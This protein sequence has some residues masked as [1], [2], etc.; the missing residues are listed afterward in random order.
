MNTRHLSVVMFTDIKGYTLLM[1]TDEAAAMKLRVRHREVFEAAHE[2]FN[3]TVIQYFGDGTLSTFKSSKDAVECAIHM[4]MAFKESPKVPLRIGLH[5]G[6]II[7]S[8][9]GIAGDAVNVASRV[10]SLGVPGSI[11]ISAKVFDDIKNQ[12]GI[13]T[14]S[15]GFFEF[16]NV[17]QPKEVF[18]IA[19]SGLVV[20]DPDTLVGK[21]KV[22]GARKEANRN[23]GHVIQDLWNRKVFL[24]AGIYLI[25]LWILLSAANFIVSNY[26]ISPYWPDVLWVFFISFLPSII[27]HSYYH[28]RLEINRMRL[29]EKITIPSNA[30]LSIALLVFLFWGKDLGATTQ[31]LVSK[32][33][34]GNKVEREVVKNEFRKETN[35]YPYSNHTSDS[36]L[37]WLESGITVMVA[38]DLAQEDYTWNGYF[39]DKE[40]LG[41][42]LEHAQST[43]A[44]YFITGHFEKEAG[45][46]VITTQLYEAKYGNLLNERTVRGENLFE[47]GDEISLQL[48]K[49][50][51]M[52]VYFIQNSPDLPISTILT[53]N[54]EAYRY[55]IQSQ[56]AAGIME[57]LNNH[58][59][60]DQ[61]DSTFALNNFFWASY[62]HYFS[63]P[64]EA[65][66]I[67]DKAMRHRKRVSQW[68]S[69][70]I[71]RMYYNIHNQPKKAIAL[72]E[73]QAE[74]FPED[75]DVYG[76]LPFEYLKNG[77]YEKALEASQRLDEIFPLTSNELFQ[78]Q[79]LTYLNRS[80]EGLDL[81]NTYVKKNPKDPQGF[82]QLGD[83]HLAL[84]N[85]DEA[86]NIFN[87]V[88]LINPENTSM[89]LMLEH[90]QYIRE[91]EED[92]LVEKF[93]PLI[94]EYRQSHSEMTA[95]FTFL[96]KKLMCQAKHQNIFQLYPIN[97]SM[98]ISSF[99]GEMTL[100]KNKE[101]KVYQIIQ[102]Q[103]RSTYIWYSLDASIQKA[104]NLL[105]EG[106]DGA[107][108]EAYKTAYAQNPDHHFLQ[109]FIQHLKFKLR[110]TA[111]PPATQWKKWLGNYYGSQNEE[112][113]R[114][115][116]LTNDVLDW[117]SPG[118]LSS[119]LLPINERAFI[120]SKQWGTKVFFHEEPGKDRWIEWV[121]EGGFKKSFVKVD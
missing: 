18:A 44:P 61:L 84:G 5:L 77:Y 72:M 85:L 62:L 103:G 110:H 67:I 53:E 117:R 37:D 31:T 46:Y 45:M 112:G 101:G 60:A 2:K 102:K 96:D 21:T 118:G 68:N 24:A 107:A 34:F 20:P 12:K 69:L 66:A 82:L 48:K 81:L 7:S 113:E 3:G 97:D 87:K 79:V 71:Q 42:M 75:G 4:Q 33:E 94:G 115:L 111:T 6:D 8:A 29:V 51:D 15:M 104:N 105:D 57:R 93:G 83:V 38:E 17:A 26:A 32:D 52:P 88:S 50:I 70:G 98:V 73:V 55:Y 11:F 64:K 109:N 23:L 74:L 63:F 95:E 10:E 100:R 41:D 39:L 22:Q 86:E 114:I 43:N 1:Q 76:Q 28:N 14:E 47:L 121:Y 99:G 78:A 13:K 16:K 25:G 90:V 49:D 27:L 116:K 91:Q 89:P 65:I 58:L 9:D 35:F 92:F 108:L 80:R 30:M 19:N 119:Q 120:L 106:K 59:K 54:V 56:H 40:A 36:T